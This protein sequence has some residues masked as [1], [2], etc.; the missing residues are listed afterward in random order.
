LIFLLASLAPEMLPAS[1]RRSHVHDGDE[2]EG[3][4]P[5]AGLLG[6]AAHEVGHGRLLR[7]IWGQ[8]CEY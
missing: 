2:V 6:V 7:V 3:L 1:A 5:E 8:Q 4:A